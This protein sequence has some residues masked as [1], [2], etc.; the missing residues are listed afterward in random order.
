MTAD[1]LCEGT[2]NP[3]HARVVAAAAKQRAVL[4]PGEPMSG[5]ALRGLKTLQ[6]TVHRWVRLDFWSSSVKD[7]FACVTCGTERVYGRSE[8]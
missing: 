8:R 2:C 4:D 5:P 7:V 6:H 1:L 3:Q